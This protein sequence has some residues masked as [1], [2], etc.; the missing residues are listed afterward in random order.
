M[1]PNDVALTATALAIILA[2]PT[3]DPNAPTQEGGI[4]PEEYRVEYVA[5]RVATFG[6]AFLG[7]TLDCA[8]CHDHKYDP[9]PQL[10]YY[11]FFAFFNNV[12][13]VGVDGRDDKDG[14][15]PPAIPA[16]TRR[17]IS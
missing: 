11:R 5:D 14:N 15:A 13:E 16:P 17:I 12:P 2:P 9:I 6:K 8:R 7:V 1:Q 4:V 3:I 10:D